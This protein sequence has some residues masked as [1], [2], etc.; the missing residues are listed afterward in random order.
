LS[1]AIPG[2]IKGYYSAKQRF[3]NPNITWA[4]LLEPSIKM[5]EEGITVSWFLDAVLTTYSNKLYEDPTLRW[6]WISG[7]YYEHIFNWSMLPLK[8]RSIFFNPKTNSTWKKGEKFKNLALAETFK[9]IAANG[10][11]EFYQGQTAKMFVEDLQ[12]LGGII[13][14]EDMKNYE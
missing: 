6:L 11:D 13:T 10:S 7:E 8:I 3:G 14:L 12:K 2:E 1:V 4:S 9:R 5:A